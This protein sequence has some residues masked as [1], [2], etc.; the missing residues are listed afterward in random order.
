MQSQERNLRGF[1]SPAVITMR[2]KTQMEENHKKMNM[3]M[4]LSRVSPADIFQMTKVSII[5]VNN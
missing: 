2:P 1:A 3:I 5:V 4:K